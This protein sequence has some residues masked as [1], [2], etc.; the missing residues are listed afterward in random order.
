M[1][2]RLHISRVDLPKPLPSSYSSHSQFH[3]D[4]DNAVSVLTYAV[5][6]LGVEH[7]I[8][9]GH[10][11]C[12]GVHAARES[13]HAPSKSKPDSPLKRWLAPLTELA[14][15]TDGDLATLVEANVREQVANI[16]KSEVIKQAWK[17]RDVHIHGWVYELE[18]GELRDLGV[19]VGRDDP[20]VSCS[21]HTAR[22]HT[23]PSPCSSSR[24]RS[25][26]FIYRSVCIAC[27]WL[28]AC[29]HKRP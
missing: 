14:R 18:T 19:S 3:L 26:S 9:V 12:G 6:H 4:D 22:V 21:S 16:L 2:D 7:V 24:V 25:S 13:A 17:K 20:Q 28:C 11:N 5:E 10:T 8:V 23:P 15:K 1:L 27:S 29:L